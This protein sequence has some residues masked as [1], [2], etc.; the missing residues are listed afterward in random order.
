[1]D[2]CVF[3][4]SFFFLIHK[5]WLRTDPCFLSN[6]T[7]VLTTINSC[8]SSIPSLSMSA[9]S[10]I[11]PSVSTG[12]LES[13]NTPFTWKY[14][15][16]H[17][18]KMHQATKY[19]VTNFSHNIFH[20]NHKLLLLVYMCEHTHKQTAITLF[21]SYSLSEATENTSAEKFSYI[22]VWCMTQCKKP[23][24]KI[25]KHNLQHSI[26]QENHHK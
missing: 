25:I 11:L 16:H 12:N 18:T 6:S 5:E 8:R 23:T 10:H 9:R 7:I 19:N 2:R 4:I 1:M 3:H 20:V 26:Q 22:N 17:I 13:I 14:K 15:G 24:F 21:C